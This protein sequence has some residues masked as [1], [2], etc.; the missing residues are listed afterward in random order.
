MQIRVNSMK[1]SSRV[2]FCSAMRVVVRIQESLHDAEVPVHGAVPWI[3]FH[4]VAG[5][6]RS[7]HRLPRAE[8]VNP[9][10]PHRGNLTHDQALFLWLVHLSSFFR[11]CSLLARWQT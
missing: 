11:S 9:E 4:R 8:P 3:C 10:P 6:Y 7:L 1:F 2:P 5:A